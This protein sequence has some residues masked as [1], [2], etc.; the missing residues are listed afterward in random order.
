MGT[1][2]RDGGRGDEEGFERGDVQMASH[3]P[4]DE[5]NDIGGPGD[6]RYHEV[7]H[8]SRNAVSGK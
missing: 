1:T 3:D 2:G 5:Q 8:E 7:D 4:Q 6:I